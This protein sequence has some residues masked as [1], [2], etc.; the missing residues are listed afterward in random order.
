MPTLQPESAA[1]LLHTFLPTVK[2]EHATT[3]KI[4]QAIPVDKGDYKPDDIAKSADELAWHLVAVEHRILAGIASG[5]FDSSAIPRPNGGI[6]SANVSAWY[7]QTFQADIERVANTSPAQLA[8]IVDF[9]GIFQL[10]AVAYL[11]FLL[12]HS[13]HHR[14]QLSTYLRPM[15]AQVPSIYG[16]SY[17][18]TQARLARA[19]S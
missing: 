1:F 10:P 14:G 9:R 2:M 13:I 7:A 12:G 11:Q 18:A 17:A 16:E 6:N 5:Q 15:G 4:I 3:L 8:Q 19:D